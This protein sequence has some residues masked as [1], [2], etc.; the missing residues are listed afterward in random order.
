MEW[1]VLPRVEPV[2]TKIVINNIVLEQIYLIFGAV[3]YLKDKDVRK[4]CKFSHICIII[5]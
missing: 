2:R 5:R 1:N 4:L 3:I